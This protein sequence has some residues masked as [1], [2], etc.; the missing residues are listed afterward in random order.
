MMGADVM[1]M[2]TGVVVPTMGLVLVWLSRSINRN[3]GA[4]NKVKE[5]LYK[6]YV[7]R[8]DYKADVD[9]IKQMIR[10]LSDKFE[11]DRRA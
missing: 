1:Q 2:F 4:I 10:D 5:E 8:N 3:A 6:E 9:E 7:R 11:A